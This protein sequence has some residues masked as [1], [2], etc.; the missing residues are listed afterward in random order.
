MW[1]SLQQQ[2]NELI[3]DRKKNPISSS[4]PVKQ[5]EQEDLSTQNLKLG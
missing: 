2:V 5:F 3:M 4:Y 1:S